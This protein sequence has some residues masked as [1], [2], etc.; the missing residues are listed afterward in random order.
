MLCTKFLSTFFKTRISLEK[1][2]SSFFIDT[3]LN[4]SQTWNKANSNVI[5]F[6]LSQTRSKNYVLRK[7]VLRY[8]F[9]NTWTFQI[10]DKQSPFFFAITMIKTKGENISHCLLHIY[11][12]HNSHGRYGQQGGWHLVLPPHQNGPHILV[13]FVVPGK[14]QGQGKTKKGELLNCI[15]AGCLKLWVRHFREKRECGQVWLSLLWCLESVY[16][17][18]FQEACLPSSCVW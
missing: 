11:C 5:S 17:T 16:I 10:C 14:V 9:L 15:V 7:N 3:W 1:R 4:L 8:M 18:S 13:H 12:S 2:I 6:Y